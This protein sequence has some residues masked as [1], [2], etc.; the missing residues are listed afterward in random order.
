MNVN[1]MA[2][3]EDRRY[4]KIERLIELLCPKEKTVLEDAA[5]YE[6][7]KPFKVGKRITVEGSSI[8]I[9]NKAYDSL[10]LKKITINTEGSLSIYDR[11][12]RKLCGWVDLNLSTKNIELFCIWA[13]MNNVPAEVVSG[14]GEKILQLSILVTVILALVLFKILRILYN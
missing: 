14:K 10:E 2:Q 8:I 3:A 6:F 11:S 5:G 4:A 1:K 7:N 13:R 9:K 12:G